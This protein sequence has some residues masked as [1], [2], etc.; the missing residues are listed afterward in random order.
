MRKFFVIY[1]HNF[2]KGCFQEIPFVCLLMKTTHSHTEATEANSVQIPN[3]E[4]KYSFNL[5]KTLSLP[6]FLAQASAWKKHFFSLCLLANREMR[7]FTLPPFRLAECVV[8]LFENC[9]KMRWII[10]FHQY[11]RR[12]RKRSLAKQRYYLPF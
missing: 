3:R 7:L 12:I 10:S 1:M 6:L 8:K 11:E 2:H 9:L 4:L 5:S